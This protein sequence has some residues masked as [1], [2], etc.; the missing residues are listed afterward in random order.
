MIYVLTWSL[1]GYVEVVRWL[2]KV[3]IITLILV[4][5]FYALKIIS[6][7]SYYSFILKILFLLFMNMFQLLMHIKINLDM[8]RLK[9]VEKNNKINWNNASTITKPTIIY[10]II[11][12]CDEL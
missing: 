5:L 8:E 10:A 7:F 9:K 4:L 3:I 1:F 12:L 11:C 6:F 2:T